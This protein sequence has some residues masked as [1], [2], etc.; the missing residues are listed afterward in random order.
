MSEIIET[1]NDEESKSGLNFVEQLVADDLAAGK[2][3][4]RLRIQK[5]IERQYQIW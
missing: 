2:N 5:K 4:G 1:I 3:G